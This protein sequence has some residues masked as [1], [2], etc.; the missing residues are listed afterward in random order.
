MSI[1]VRHEAKT[2]SSWEPAR[3]LSSFCD[4]SS[5]FS[6]NETAPGR[7]TSSNAYHAWSASRTRAQG[8]WLTLQTLGGT[9][10][11]EPGCTRGSFTQRS[12]T[13][14]VPLW[15][16]R[17]RKIRLGHCDEEEGQM[18]R[19]SEERGGRVRGHVTRE[20]KLQSDLRR[21]AR[22]CCVELSTKFYY[23]NIG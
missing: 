16:G 8:G 13:E 20:G 11:G 14:T 12:A 15:C 2:G 18:T 10:P 3:A 7:S 6:M 21:P 9:S 4:P 23:A 19:G 17:Q 5:I 22:G 1:C